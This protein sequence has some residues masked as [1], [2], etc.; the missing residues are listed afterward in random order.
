[1]TIGAIAEGGELRLTSSERK[2]FI[3]AALAARTVKGY[4]LEFGVGA[5]VSLRWI[6]KSTKETIYGFDS[7]EGLP[8]DWQFN[9]HIIFAKGSFKYPPKNNFSH[10][11]L[12]EGWFEDTIPKWKAD[13]PG[14]ISFLHIDADLYSSCKTVLTELNHQIVPGTILLFDEL[15]NYPRWEEGEWKAFVEWQ[16]EYGR[17]V[18][19]LGTNWTQASY[20]IIE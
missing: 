13:N 16:E 11:E 8:E 10:V 7:F 6:A 5:G 17:K 2:E 4:V 19:E 9:D 12:V 1:V 20:R 14:A 3:E 18:H 15:I